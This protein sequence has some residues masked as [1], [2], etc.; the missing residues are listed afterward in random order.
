MRAGKGALASTTRLD[1]I[2]LGSAK[3]QP[4]P[5]AELPGAPNPDARVRA[6]ALSFS[7]TL[8]R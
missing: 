6:G 1:P 2:G 8:L 7:L 3:A 5:G 4:A